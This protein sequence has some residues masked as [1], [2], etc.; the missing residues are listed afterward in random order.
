V[1]GE[2]R[3]LLQSDQSNVVDVA[4][5][6]G[7]KQVVVNLT[8]AENNSLDL[9]GDDGRVSLTIDGTKS[10]V[11]SSIIE[12]VEVRLASLVSQQ[13]LRGDQNKRLAVLSVD[14]SSQNVEV[15]GG[16]GA[17]GDGPVGTLN[18]FLIGHGREC[19]EVLVGELEETLNTARAVLRSSTL[20]TVRK[21]H[22]QTRLTEPLVLTRGDEL[23]N[24]DLGTVGEVTEL[25][26]PKDQSVGVF[27]GVS[28]LESKLGKLGEG[29]VRELS[30]LALGRDVVQWSVSLAGLL[31]VQN[32][33][34][35]GEC[36][37]LNVL[38]SETDMVA[39]KQ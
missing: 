30:A 28:K 32:C 31:V 17:V 4:G 13:T 38:T 14:L 36:T 12:A 3:E 23:I 27:K 9:L 11:I 1:E 18:D 19:I 22:N 21:E 20:I 33:V 24:D 25:S 5:L 37:S 15:V 26:L 8:R 39:L 29:G 16:G 34:A 6:S 35:L 7:L 10:G 2:G